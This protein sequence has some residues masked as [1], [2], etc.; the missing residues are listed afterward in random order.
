MQYVGIDWAYRHARWCAISEQGELT[1]E[2][3]TPADEDGLLRLVA[4]LG[5]DVRT[6][7]ELMSGAVSVRDRL[8][9]AGWRVEV[10]DARRVKALAPLAAK[11]DK[12]DARLL[13]TLA[14]RDLVPAV[15]V[16]SLTD[17]GQDD[18]DDLREQSRE[19]LRGYL[20]QLAPSV[21]PVSAERRFELRFDG[22][23]WSIV[24]YLDIE[25]QSGDTVDVKIGAK[26][27]SEA[28][29]ERDPQP[30]VY[31]L[32]CRTEGRPAGR[33]LFHSIRRGP[34]RSGERCLVVPAPRSAA[35]LVAMESR[36]A[37]TARQIA[38]C[39]ETGDWPLS[40]PDGWWCAPGQC[41]HWRDCPAGSPF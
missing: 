19:A 13:A 1:A 10:A 25:D 9:R 36:I 7:I 41:R 2:A 29:A 40:S 35:Q 34:I 17:F 20:E 11:T 32:A 5:P 22:A 24:G 6:C 12:V 15:W 16:Q 37:Q 27:V 30:T 3:T 28:R 8:E 18:P 39:V 4:R 33:F 26:H 14:F 38:R 31:G 23:E 21:R